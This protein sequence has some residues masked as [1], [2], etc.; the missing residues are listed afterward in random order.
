MKLHSIIFIL[1][2]FLFNLSAC[3]EFVHSPYEGIYKNMPKREVIAILGDPDKREWHGDFEDWHYTRDLRVI[4]FI[5]D[6]VE[7]ISE[8]KAEYTRLR[9]IR[10]AKEAKRREERRKKFESPQLFEEE[11]KKDKKYKRPA[12]P[13][14]DSF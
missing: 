1:L 14:K 8:D 5:D 13:N 7:L 9:G 12:L 3:T 2:V 10:L 11:L 4:S 6:R